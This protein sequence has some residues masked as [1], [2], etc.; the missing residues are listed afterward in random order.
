MQRNNSNT[1]GICLPQPGFISYL[2][3]NIWQ[4]ANLRKVYFGSQF[5]S[6]VHHVVEIMVGKSWEAGHTASKDRKQEGRNSAAQ[7][8]FWFNTRPQM[9][10]WHHP[11]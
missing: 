6:T 2:G 7:L 8:P 10:E 5:K 9:E 1:G 11:H 3:Q 4:K